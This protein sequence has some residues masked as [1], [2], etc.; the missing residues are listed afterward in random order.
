MKKILILIGL[1]VIA[2][3]VVIFVKPAVKETENANNQQQNPSSPSG[4]EQQKVVVSTSTVSQ[5]DSFYDINANYPQFTNVDPAFNK[6]ISDLITGEIVTFKQ[7]AE[8][9]W[10]ARK[11]TA[12]P[13][14]V[15]PQNPEEPFDFVSNWS[16]V[17]INDNYISFVETIYYFS[18]GAHG[19]TE[20]K[21]FNYDVA[22]SQTISIVDFLGDSQLSKLSQLA[23]S[24][25]PNIIESGTQDTVLTQMIKDGTQPTVENFQD[26]NFTPDSLIIYFQQ[27]Q[28]APGSY[29][30]VTITLPKAQLAQNSITSDYLK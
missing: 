25:I 1:F 16:A 3:V 12:A 6:K 26:F 10:A 20:I 29:G 23:Q 14:E 24:E 7:N 13:G 15:I 4:Q 17:Q 30:P 8:D 5:K 22:K 2:A 21:A 11:A 27:Y 18:G 9:Y 19:I 28:V